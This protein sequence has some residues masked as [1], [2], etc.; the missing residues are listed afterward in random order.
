M[1]RIEFQK[2]NLLKYAGDLS[3]VFS[4]KEYTLS[5]GKAQGIKAIDV[6]NGS[7]L[8]FTVLPDRGMDVAWLSYKGINFSYIGKTGIVAPQFFNENGFGFLRSFEAGFLTTCGLMNVGSPCDDNGENYGLHG[9]ISNTPAENVASEVNWADGKPI[10]KVRGKMRE[11]RVFGENLVFSREIACQ[12]GEKRFSILDTVENDGFREEPLM[13]LYH[14]NLGYPL[15]DE[16]AVFAAPTV[17]LKARDE[18]A[19]K[20]I[21]TCNVFQKPTANYKEQVFYRNLKTDRD[22][23]TCAALINA[24][25]GLGVVIRFNKSQLFNLT[26]WK[27]MGEGEYVLG[28]EPG[29][30][31]VEGRLDAK[32]KGV[33]EYL[34]PGE[35][36]KFKIDVEILEGSS[37]LE[38][39]QNEISKF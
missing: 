6:K 25:L 20:G 36:R 33:L 27:Q 28:I 35:I 11:A 12:C 17:E 16:N 15:L 34:N 31:Y 24:A 18:E 7:G 13:L 29:N 22:G 5:S 30:C 38:R 3:Q 26:Q 2:R 1:S 37:D 14:F 21:G 39:V 4:T 32:R 10:I 23:N 8:E 19:A 9:R